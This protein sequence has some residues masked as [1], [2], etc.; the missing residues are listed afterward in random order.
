MLMLSWK[1]WE[2]AISVSSDF[3]DRV[4]AEEMQWA[5]LLQLHFSDQLDDYLNKGS[6]RDGEAILQERTRWMPPGYA[7]LAD[8]KAGATHAAVGGQEEHG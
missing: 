7:D 8:K 2:L 6:D 4:K 3:L 1:V 5:P